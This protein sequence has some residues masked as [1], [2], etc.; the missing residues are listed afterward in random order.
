M[1][2][3]LYF[4]NYYYSILKLL[5]SLSVGKAIPVEKVLEPSQEDIDTLHE[6]YVAGLKDVFET[7]KT[8]FNIDASVQLN[9]IG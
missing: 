7:N 9:F 1:S 8:R 5:C 2:S 4:K 3:F 6:K